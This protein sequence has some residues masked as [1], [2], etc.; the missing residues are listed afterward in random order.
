MAEVGTSPP[1]NSRQ[2]LQDGVWLRGVAGGQNRSYI[3]GL[4][5][6]AGGTKAAGLQIPAGVALVQFDTVASGSDSALLPNAL[7]GMTFRLANSGAS[8]M[9]V[10][11][12]GTDTIND[13]ATATNYDIATN[14]SVDFF[15]AKNGQWK[16]IKSA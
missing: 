9:S 7:A 14:V 13:A 8:T 10:Y 6:T 11:G 5:A 2:A 12:R 15:C 1:V 4:T 3:N 16:A